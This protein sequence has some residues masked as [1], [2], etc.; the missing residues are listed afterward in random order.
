V[1]KV[2]KVTSAEPS[3][4]ELVWEKLKHVPEPKVKFEP[5]M[6]RSIYWSTQVLRADKA[7]TIVS[8]TTA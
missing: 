7:I 3:D 1:A 5:L 8:D 6:Y 4:K 2:K